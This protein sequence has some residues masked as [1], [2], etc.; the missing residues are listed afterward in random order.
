MMT[1]AAPTVL[2]KGYALDL[3]RDLL[4]EVPHR[5]FTA[6]VQAV[7]S[8]LHGRSFPERRTLANA[9]VMLTRS[10]GTS[11]PVEAMIRACITA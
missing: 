9:F 2:S 10:T 11:K 3:A 8:I 4:A 7:E 1:A 5:P 6:L